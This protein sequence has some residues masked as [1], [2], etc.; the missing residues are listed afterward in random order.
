MKQKYARASS[1]NLKESE[2]KVIFVVIA[3]FLWVPYLSAQ[4]PLDAPEKEQTLQAED[5]SDVVK[6]VWDIVKKGADDYH[7]ELHSRNEFETATD[8]D[9]RLQQRHNDIAA[10]IQAFAE[11][12]KISERLFAVWLPARLVKYNPDTQTYTISTSTQ[13]QVPPRSEDVATLCPQNQYISL[14][15]KSREGYRFA[16]LSLSAKPEYTWHVDKQTAQGAKADEPNVFFKVWFRIDISQAF[17]GTTGE[18]MIIPIKIALVN[19]GSN[20]T[21][22]SDDI[23]K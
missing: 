17:V 8:F 5:F 7:D 22:W 1:L 19:K 11:S 10:K 13:I 15:E 2:M 23:L 14:V 16:N 20:V 18:I 9:A 21:Y 6:S 3:W 4:S 12:K